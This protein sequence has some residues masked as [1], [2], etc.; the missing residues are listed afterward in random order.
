MSDVMKIYCENFGEYVDIRGGESLGELA[1]TLA[2]RL[3]IEPIC[4]LVNN[5]T[6]PL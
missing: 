6:E 5:K 4:A 3:G 1:E 2:S